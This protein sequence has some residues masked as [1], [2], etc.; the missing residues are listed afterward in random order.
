MNQ[1]PGYWQRSIIF[2]MVNQEMIAQLNRIVS[3]FLAE[4]NFELVEFIHRYEGRDL[5]LRLLVDKPE[6]SISMGE[7]AQLNRRIGQLLDEK[8]IIA[9]RYILEVSSPGLDRPLKTR[10][11]FMRCLNKQ[12]V[13]FLN[14]LVND[15]CQ[16]QGLI[17]KVGEH[18]VFIIQSGQVLEV[19]L[20]K[21]NK[22]KLVI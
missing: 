20:T 7:C 16:W 14:D 15:R 21:I 10:E 22:A 2:I 4:N 3:D 1:P 9:S 19:P 13:F 12:A 17:S 8:D 6:G 11:D 18:S 5:V